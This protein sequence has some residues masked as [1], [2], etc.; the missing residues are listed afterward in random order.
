[1]SAVI[2]LIAAQMIMVVFVAILY[3]PYISNLPNFVSAVILFTG[4]II[5]IYVSILCFKK[6][7]KYLK[8]SQ[9]T[10]GGSV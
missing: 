9:N 8:E 2:A 6:T 3:A 4:I 10:E 5:A 1:M 7:S